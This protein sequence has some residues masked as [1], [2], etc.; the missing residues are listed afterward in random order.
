MS[1]RVFVTGA[2]GLIGKEVVRDLVA[3][4]VS[5]VAL[6]AAEAKEP[7]PDGV[8]A[9]VRDVRDVTPGDLE[10]CESVIHLAALTL[11]AEDRRFGQAERTPTSAEAMLGVNV[12]AT[13]NLFRSAIAA[14]VPAVAYASTAAVYGGAHW[15]GPAEGGVSRQGPF[16]PGSL[17][18]HTKLMVEGLADFYGAAS[19]T[20]FIGIRPTFSYGLGRLIGVSGMFAQWIV[21][22]LEGRE[23]RLP[24]P[25]GRSGQLQLIYSVDMGRTFTQAAGAAGDGPRFDRLGGN[26]SL[27]FNSPTSQ[28]LSMDVIVEQVRAASQNE[29]VLVEAAHFSPQIQM[30]L[31]DTRSVIEFLGFDQQFPLDVAI[32]DMR[33]VVEGA[34]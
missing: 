5:V 4:D 24:V 31:M 13:D 1:R 30:P 10:G 6:D 7:W 18:A 9:L 15:H 22:A 16:R 33:R 3:Q 29:R 26:G 34:R 28:V 19:D 25:F 20:R 23:A 21:D 27:V 17:Y 2:S 32:E 11:S 8:D 14:G 12:L